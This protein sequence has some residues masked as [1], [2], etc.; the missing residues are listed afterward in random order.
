[1]AYYDLGVL[2]KTYCIIG[3]SAAGISAA[4]QIRSLDTSV[5]II[6]FSAHDELPYNVC[7]LTHFLRKEKSKKDLHLKPLSWF[8]E[9]S[10]ELKVGIRIEQIKASEKCVVDQNG[11]CYYYEKLLIAVGTRP[12]LPCWF[13]TEI[14][15]VFPFYSL[16]DAEAIQKRLTTHPVKTILVIGGG[17]NGLECADALNT[18]GYSVTVLEAQ[19]YFLYQWFTAE[20]SEKLRSYADACG[21]SLVSGECVTSIENCE[22]KVV[23]TTRSGITYGADMVIVAT[24]SIPATDFLYNS[25]IACKDR[26]II[27]NDYMQTSIPD[28]FA[29]GDCALVKNPHFLEIQASTRW[30]DAVAQECVQENRC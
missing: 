14:D 18:C 16:A 30:S 22:N 11:I 26:F 5:R 27:T 2:V 12:K 15:G 23:I 25:G 20:E 4:T 24:G 13:N 21:V 17:I 8:H 6:V 29:A 7:L 3:A 28:I 9:N 19:P 10:I 1:M